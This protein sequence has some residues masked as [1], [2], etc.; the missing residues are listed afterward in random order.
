MPEKI[1]KVDNCRVYYFTSRGINKALDNI[2]FEIY[3][4]EIL[5][6]AGE[7]GCGKSTLIK[8]LYGMIL[9]PL[10]VVEG[11]ILLFD[12]NDTIDL[13]SLSDESLRNLRWKYI[14]YMPQ[15]SMNVMNPVVR[16]EEQFFEVLD[17]RTE[18]TKKI[19]KNQ[20][21]EIISNYLRDMGLPSPSKLLKSY[22]HQLS[23]GMRQRVIL[24]MVTFL[25]PKIILADEPT[26][27]LDVVVQKG[28]LMMMKKIQRERKNTLI[29]VSHDMGVHYQMADRLLIMYAGKIV[30]LGPKK[31]IF[32]NPLHP[33]TKFLIDSLPRI[34]E[35]EKR[36]GISGEPPDLLSPPH[37]CRFHP[38]CPYK[39]KICEDREPKFIKVSD[40]HFVACHLFSKKGEMNYG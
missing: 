10:K 7:S 12:N 5:G 33:Y 34:G 9:P 28:I 29:F 1:L 3:K 18:G 6:I 25:N 13:F 32:E 4:G 36:K 38:R 40:D 2:N 17:K 27:A 19:S 31:A 30:E 20:A 15:G 24:A 14:S 11:K 39:K 8:S 21:R 37:G 26:T 35:K 22:P 16:I 23:G